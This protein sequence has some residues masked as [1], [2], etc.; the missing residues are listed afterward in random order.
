MGFFLILNR[1]GYFRSVLFTLVLLL[2]NTSTYGFF[3]IINRLGYF[4]RLYD[5]LE[6]L[7]DYVSYSGHHSHPE[8]C[9]GNIILS[10]SLSK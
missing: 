7:N 9:V 3:L 8:I 5:N 10:L 6:S 1:V 4:M 2:I